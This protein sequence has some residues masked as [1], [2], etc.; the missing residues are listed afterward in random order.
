MFY[1]FENP[2][3]W[4]LQDNYFD[5]RITENALFGFYEGDVVVSTQQDQSTPQKPDDEN[6]PPASSDVLHTAGKTPKQTPGKSSFT[7]AVQLLIEQTSRK[8]V[9]APGPISHAGC[10][11]DRFRHR[12]DTCDH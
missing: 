10:R 4:N 3:L 8:S 2:R 9:A 12:T 6:V 7:N 5:P 1:D 11:L